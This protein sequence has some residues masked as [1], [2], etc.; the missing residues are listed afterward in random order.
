MDALPD[1][2]LTRCG[3]RVEEW[4][5]KLALHE[6]WWRLERENSKPEGA[7]WQAAPAL[8]DNYLRFRLVGE[9]QESVLDIGCGDGS[10]AAHV[11]RQLYVGID[12]LILQA[13]YAFPFFRGLAEFLPFADGSFV[14]ASAVEVL[15]HVLDPQRALREMVRV[16]APAGA[17]FL[18]VGLSDTEHATAA[19]MERQQ[20][21]ST[22]EADV[23][24][25][26]FTEDF[27]QAALMDEF[28]LV[29]TVRLTGY[30]AVWGWD[31]L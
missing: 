1:R 4:R 9:D 14:R 3:P 25:H 10:R 18:F 8:L 24:L 20:L 16:L 7:H 11:R 5:R 26:R 19:T 15:D 29:E 28:R 2:L 23:H 6:R 31:R 21:Y 12:P 27:L 17:L 13:P 30:I 22:T